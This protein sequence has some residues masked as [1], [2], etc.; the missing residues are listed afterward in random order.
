MAILE[1][2]GEALQQGNATETAA[3]TRQ[4]L[5]QG[6][7]PQEIIDRALIRG[8]AVI[9]ER[10]RQNEVFVPELLIA[11]RAMNKALEL[12]EPYLI[13][14]EVV[15]AGTLVIGTVQGDLH[16][17]GKNLTAIMFK[18]AGYKVVDLGVDVSAERF[19]AAALEHRADFV[20]LSALLTTTMIGMKDIIGTLK[21][22]GVGAK[23]LV[24]GAPVTAN[25]AREI[26][27]DGYAPDAASAVAVARSQSQL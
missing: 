5:D 1:Q 19:A 9:G 13:S 8:M 24:G 3:L 11:A 17:I 14:G 6:I 23:V 20:G 25:F 21:A 16:D 26:G 22:G 27:A 2:I 15:S 18:G 12:L 4:A 7:P 10:F